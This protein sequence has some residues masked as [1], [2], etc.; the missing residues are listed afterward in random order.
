MTSHSHA[1]S[2][3]QLF[4]LYCLCRRSYHVFAEALADVKETSDSLYKC[5]A[6]I[7]SVRTDCCSL[8]TRLIVTEPTSAT[9]AYWNIILA[10]HNVVNIWCSYGNVTF[11]RL[12]QI[13]LLEKG[14]CL[15]NGTSSSTPLHPPVHPHNLLQRLGEILCNKLGGRYAEMGAKEGELSLC[16]WNALHPSIPHTQQQP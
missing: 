1:F 9:L 16:E 4:H 13:L 15:C 10:M 12:Y 2:Y 8:V 11:L 6:G 3:K 7:S 5:N 14:I